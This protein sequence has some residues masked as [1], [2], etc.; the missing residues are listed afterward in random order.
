MNGTTHLTA[1]TLIRLGGAA[2]VGVWALLTVP[3]PSASAVPSATSVA[4]PDVEVVF[5]RGTGEAPGAG[6]FGDAFIDALHSKIGTKSMGV[7]A[8]NYPAS[9]DF[10]T[11]LLGIQDARDHVT[12]MAATCPQTKEVLGGF[13]QGAAVMGFVTSAAVPDGAPSDVPQPMPPEVANH[14]AAV[15]LFGTPSTR[16][17]TQFGQPTIVIGPPYVAKT[18]EYCAE[19]DPVCGDGGEFGAHNA[20]VDNGMI[21]Q[22][23]SF[24]ASRLSAATTS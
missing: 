15:T 18:T 3:A 21:D 16:F 7:Y 9:S 11:A 19:G 22:A 4:C 1:K 5:A 13:S 8:V 12:Q 6:F 10:P 17:M 20:Y 14:V 23:A 2:V 24:A